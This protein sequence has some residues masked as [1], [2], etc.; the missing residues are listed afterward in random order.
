MVEQKVQKAE[1][2]RFETLDENMQNFLAD[3]KNSETFL[4]LLNAAGSPYESSC[5][6]KLMIRESALEILYNFSSIESYG[7]FVVKNCYDIVMRTFEDNLKKAKNWFR[8][9]ERGIQ[10]SEDSA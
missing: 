4:E 9:R 1:C 7:L 5:E 8:D 10:I 2:G 6:A 3:S